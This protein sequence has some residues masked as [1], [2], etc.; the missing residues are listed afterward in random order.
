MTNISTAPK[1]I[2][3]YAM[4]SFFALPITYV[5]YFLAG[6]RDD[7]MMRGELSNAVEQKPGL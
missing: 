5:E 2:H 4:G 6:L 3:N 7:T 1:P